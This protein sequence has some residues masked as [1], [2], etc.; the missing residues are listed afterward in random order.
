MDMTTQ[1]DITPFDITQYEI[2]EDE[3]QWAN[4]GGLAIADQLASVSHHGDRQETDVP[5]KTMPPYKAY[6]ITRKE[7]MKVSIACYS[8]ILNP[9]YFALLV[10]FTFQL[11]QDIQDI[12]CVELASDQLQ[13]VG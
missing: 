10:P 13:K 8:H 5:N 7:R 6:R 12:P 11:I 9:Y 2:T 3:I 1:F 4:A